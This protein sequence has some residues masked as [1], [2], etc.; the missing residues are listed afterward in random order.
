MNFEKISKLSQRHVWSICGS[1][2]CSQ[3]SNVLFLSLPELPE[4][5]PP[6][7]NLSS[8]NPQNPAYYT[9]APVH[10]QWP[11]YTDLDSNA[12]NSWDSVPESA[13]APSRNKRE[14]CR[15]CGGKLSPVDPPYSYDPAKGIPPGFDVKCEACDRHDWSKPRRV[16]VQKHGWRRFPLQSVLAWR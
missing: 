12:D 16:W 8:S 7:K 6:L 4:G 1:D 15:R 5:N 11:I 3:F 9:D 2:S 13:A 10:D 14:F